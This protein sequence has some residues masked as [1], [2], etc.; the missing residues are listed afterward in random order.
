MLLKSNNILTTI[1]NSIVFVLVLSC[2][3]QPKE[4]K[5]NYNLDSALLLL[6]IANQLLEGDAVNKHQWDQL[7]FSPGYKQYLIYSDSI[8]KR[9][10]LK[11]ALILAFNPEKKVEL[12]SVLAI[13]IAVNKHMYRN[14][15]IKNFYDLRQNI[16]EVKAF[17]NKTD[18]SK[19][20]HKA[21]SI[22]KAYL[23]KREKFNCKDLFSVYF[24][25][26]DPDG[27]VANNAIIIDINMAAKLEHSHELDR[28]IAH[29]F[30]HNYRKLKTQVWSN[31]LLLNIN[32]IH[33]EG[34]ADLIDK[35]TPPIEALGLY[36]K[37]I[38]NMYNVD[39]QNTPVN[40]KLLDSLTLSYKN[41]LI[42]KKEYKAKIDT[43]IKFGG[44]TMGFYMSN[45]IRSEIGIEP[46]IKTYNKPI[47][48]IKLYNKVAKNKANEY[49]L[50]K[51]FTKYLKEIE[52]YNF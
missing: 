43:L 1:I 7:F 34:M 28:M 33:Q 9:Q 21:D 31:P 27:M 13:P 40:L 52:L 44:H 48:F 22:A 41:H 18:F 30:H 29:E 46:L 47:A 38:I 8:S 2:N 4:A 12:D 5:Y 14:I 11:E 16:K 20:L 6:D 15:L 39:Y 26:S 24:I 17:I 10:K 50:S 37:A 32:K 36:P 42:E 45:L 3:G 25:G 23:P 35:K 19:V 49:V 51:E